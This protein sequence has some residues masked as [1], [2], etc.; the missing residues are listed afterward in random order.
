MHHH[1]IRLSAYFG[2]LVESLSVL[3]PWGAP[4]GAVVVVPHLGGEF[5]HLLLG[6]LG[7]GI[8]IG[9]EELIDRI[10]RIV[11]VLTILVRGLGGDEVLLHILGVSTHLPLGG[12][13]FLAGLDVLGN[14]PILGNPLHS[15]NDLGSLNTERRV[16]FL[17]D[18]IAVRFVVVG[19]DDH[20][21]VAPEIVEGA[22]IV[23][24]GGVTLPIDINIDDALAGEGET[25]DFVIPIEF[26]ISRNLIVGIRMSSVLL[27]DITHHGEGEGEIL[28]GIRKN[29]TI[30]LGGLFGLYHN[31]CC[32]VT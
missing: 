11:G 29:V 2:E 27:E 31:A 7:E 6:H 32:F 19:L 22:A 10:A 13:L 16:P 14:E 28:V 8:R 12:L 9:P 30:E 17:T 4:I 18:T 24:I 23:P 3:V 20:F 5:K 15:G 21:I 26:H 25:L 1:P